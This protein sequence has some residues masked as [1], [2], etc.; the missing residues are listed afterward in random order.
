M[1]EYERAE[2]ARRV[3]STLRELPKRQQLALVLRDVNGLSVGE[4]ASVLGLT[5]GSADVLLSRAR[6]G[7]RRVFLAGAGVADRTLRPGRQSPRRRR[8]PRRARPGPR[9]SSTPDVPGLPSRRRA[10]WGAAPVGL[11]LL[12]PQVALPAKL[13]LGATLAAAQAAG[14]AV[15]GRARRGRRGRSLVGGRER[16]RWRGRAVRGCR[17]GSAGRCDGGTPPAGAG[18]LA[19][20][21][22]A[23]GVKIAT[24]AV[25]ATAAVGIAGVH[26]RSGTQRPA[27]GASRPRRAGPADGVRRRRRPGR[28]RHGARRRHL[29]ARAHARTGAGRGLDGRTACAAPAGARDRG[30]AW[31]GRPPGHRAGSPTATG[32]WRRSGVGAGGARGGA[33]GGGLRRA[34]RRRLRPASGS[35]RGS[36]RRSRPEHGRRLAQSGIRRRPPAG[37]SAP[38]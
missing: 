1:D 11:G 21:G 13:S 38:E 36:G 16:P 37:C 15:A 18:L 7:F 6:A 22:S 32:G 24:L 25:V 14:I 2:L 29:R 10:L 35:G 12:L 19:A 23:A 26:A 31:T 4:T 28:R 20:L 5:K 33:S 27:P 3:E 9:C 34:V 17:R 30:G 8:R